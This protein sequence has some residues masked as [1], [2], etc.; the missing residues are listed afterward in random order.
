M[1]LWLALLTSGYAAVVRYK[2]TAGEHGEIPAQWPSASALAR[3]SVGKTLVMAAHPHC[4]CTRASISELARLLSRAGPGVT[5]QVLFMT[6]S[7]VAPGWEETALFRRAQEIDGV[8]VV[9]D[10]DGV[11]AERFGLRTSGHTALYDENGT[12]LFHGG[13]TPARGHE[14]ESAGQLAVVKLVRGESAT[15]H[16][17][18]VFGCGLKDHQPQGGSP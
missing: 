2:S 18:K 15:E 17:A 14:G 13:I 5:A 1:A 3:S 10:R 4:P 12:L 9:R 11:E 7:D 8:T 6:P 16:E